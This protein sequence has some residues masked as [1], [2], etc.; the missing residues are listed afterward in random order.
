LAQFWPPLAGKSAAPA[1]TG[2]G[3]KAGRRAVVEERDNDATPALGR[4]AAGTLA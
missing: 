2:Q 4:S 1:C 3:H